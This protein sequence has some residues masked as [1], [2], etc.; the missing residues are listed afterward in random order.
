MCSSRDTVGE[1]TINKRWFLIMQAQ[2]R[3]KEEV[4]NKRQ[5]EAT[6]PPKVEAV[7]E[8][9]IWEPITASNKLYSTGAML[10]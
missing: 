5:R 9:G 1:S 10:L 8:E 4:E 7:G 3:M 2:K 6:T